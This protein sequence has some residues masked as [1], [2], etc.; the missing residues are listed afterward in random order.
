MNCKDCKW[1]QVAS[2]NMEADWGLREPGSRRVEFVEDGQ[3]LRELYGVGWDVRYCLSPKLKFYEYPA[4]DGASVK[5]GSEYWAALVTAPLFG[6]VNFEEV[7][8]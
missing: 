7:C 1:W 3:S 2:G 6:C 5:D 8:A 4:E